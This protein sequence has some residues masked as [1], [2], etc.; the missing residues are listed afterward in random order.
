MRALSHALS[1]AGALLLLS[2]SGADVTEPPGSGDDAELR[3]T[4][5]VVGTPIDLMV[6]RVTASDIVTPLVFNLPVANGVATGTLRVPPGTA[7]TITLEAFDEAGDI[8]HEGSAT[9]DVRAGQ[10][11]PVS[12]AMLPRGGQVPVTATI[13][14][15]SIIIS[16]SSASIAEGATRQ[17][18][19]QILGPDDQP[20]AGA[21]VWAVTNPALARVDP[22]GVVTGVRAGT[23]QLVATFG[24]VAG[25][26]QVTVT[27]GVTGT[28]EG[29]VSSP[30]F[31]DLAGVTVTA[32]PY[33]GT[34][35]T[36]GAYTLSSVA[37]GTYQVAISGLPTGCTAP[38][39]Q[40]VTVTAG[41]VSTTDFS[42]ACTI[43]VNQVII[44]EFMAHPVGTQSSNGFESGEWIELYNGTSAEVDITG[45]GLVTPSATT[46]TACQIGQAVIP[47]G[48][49]VVVGP[50]TDP[51]LNGGLHN[52]ISCPG[53]ALPNATPIQLILVTSET[54][55]VDGI[56][57]NA[58]VEGASWS[59]SP[60][61]HGAAANDAASSW[62]PGVTGYGTG[63]N[64]GT[65]GAPNSP[66]D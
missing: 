57:T 60:A 11:P 3:V 51:F 63:G 16:P 1:V 46:Q 28:I 35:G 2:C 41:V 64:L 48:G 31:G 17:F 40:S 44:T 19:A 50:V 18:T 39:P 58:N 45:W 8:T 49:Y 66:C 23:L 21:V 15:V 27:D 6:A 38:A 34:T 22:G 7:R 25:V 65:P 26:A 33:S 30:D 12:I 52:V 59:L 53:L 36:G 42:V 37:E 5:L 4:A 24:G 62:C 43:S 54:I 9:I 47:A 13:A 32:G 29:T 55:I 14:D 61:S 20:V 56:G 10:N